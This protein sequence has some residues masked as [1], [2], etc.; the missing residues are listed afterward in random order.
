MRGSESDFVSLSPCTPSVQISQ[1]HAGGDEL[2]DFVRS[3][4]A[5]I[6]LKSLTRFHDKWAH[7]Y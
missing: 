2:P 4:D 7:S 6:E 1:R 3:Y 5:V